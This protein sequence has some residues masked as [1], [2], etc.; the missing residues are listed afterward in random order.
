MQFQAEIL[1][2]IKCI[3]IFVKIILLKFLKY[4]SILILLQFFIGTAK[5]INEFLIEKI[6]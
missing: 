3:K 4:N 6:N 1:H 5:R 2:F